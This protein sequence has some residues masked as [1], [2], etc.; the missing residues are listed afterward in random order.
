MDPNQN[1][2]S[3]KEWSIQEKEDFF[4]SQDALTGILNGVPNQPP[5]EWSTGA[6]NGP[7]IPLDPED[8]FGDM[9]RIFSRGIHVTSI[10]HPEQGWLVAY[11]CPLC[12]ET[13]FLLNPW[14]E[15]PKDGD[16]LRM[17]D[18]CVNEEY[19]HRHNMQMALTA[20]SNWSG[21]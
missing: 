10:T 14:A 9:E 16:Y 5:I 13:V 2:P 11:H 6:W 3:E 12:K 21:K 15:K 8:P 1:P 7:I 18:T 19:H 17:N 20:K 4:K